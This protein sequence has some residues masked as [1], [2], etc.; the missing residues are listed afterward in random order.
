[1]RLTDRMHPSRTIGVDLAAEPAG[2][3][4]AVVEWT[5]AGAHLIELH[6]G[7]DD[8]AIVAASDSGARIGIDCA[9]GWPDDF[10]DFVQ[11]HAAGGQPELEVDGGKAWRSRLAYR[12]TD[13]LT[14]ERTGRW[15]LS[16]ATDRLGVTALRCAGLLRRLGE[17]GVEVDRSGGGGIAEVYPGGALR[18]WG[19]ETRGYRV[20][21]Q[22]RAVL[23][24]ALTASAPQLDLERHREL[25]ISS[26]DAFDAV[27]AAL[28]T[29]A[30]V[31]GRYRAPAP[32]EQ[33]ARARREGWIVLPECGLDELVGGRRT[34]AP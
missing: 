15:P 26:T 8:T 9:F 23:L 3:A 19:F 4:L 22:A 32:G 5:D 30:A 20:D 7:V 6:I 25:M 16:V 34:L 11:A 24:D 10:V 28:A 14:R 2:T 17:A 21:A 33:L 1:M 29:R 27:I 13:R 31:L 12:E 18:L